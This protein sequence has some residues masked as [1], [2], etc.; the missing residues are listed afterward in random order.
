[1]WTSQW[2]LVVV[3]M[4]CYRSRKAQERGSEPHLAKV[5]SDNG[6]EKHKIFDEGIGLRGA[7]DC[8]K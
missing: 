4:R 8:S 1:M 3:A 2:L 7:R 5:L 6:G